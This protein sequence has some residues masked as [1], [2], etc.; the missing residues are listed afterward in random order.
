MGGRAPACRAS[1]LLRRAAARVA[2]VKTSTA[3]PP[4]TKP[5]RKACKEMLVGT[6]A[7]ASEAPLSSKKIT[8]SSLTTPNARKGPAITAGT[9]SSSP[10][11]RPRMPSCQTMA[12][13]LLSMAIS[14]DL[15]RTIK[16]ATSAK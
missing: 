9:A 14:P 8:P 4:P 16:P 1:M 10:S 15:E 2:M 11:P 13:R 7:R 5:S 3:S 12:P 6:P